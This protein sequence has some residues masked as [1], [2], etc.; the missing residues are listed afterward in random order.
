[1][2]IHEAN[3]VTTKVHSPVVGSEATQAMRQVRP[4]GEC[5]R[6]MAAVATPIQFVTCTKTSTSSFRHVD[7]TFLLFCSFFVSRVLYI[8]Q[9]EAADCG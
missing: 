9:T 8:G 7:G 1:M 2:H 5:N 6:L 3:E 4:A